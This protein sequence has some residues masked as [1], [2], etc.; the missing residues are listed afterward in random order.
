MSILE[1]TRPTRY[2]I[3]EWAHYT[4]V[5]NSYIR[6]ESHY[7]PSVG[8]PVTD[9]SL[10]DGGWIGIYEKRCVS[11]TF[12]YALLVVCAPDSRTFDA[13][14][15]TCRKDHHDLSSVHDTFE[16]VIRPYKDLAI[17]TRIA[18]TTRVAE[19]LGF[20]TGAPSASPSMV[21]WF[22][23]VP[24][25][26]VGAYLPRRRPKGCPEL[27]DPFPNAPLA[28]MRRD[29]QIVDYLLDDFRVYDESTY[30]RYSMC[31]SIRNGRHVTVRGPFD[32]VHIQHCTDEVPLDQVAVLFGAP[33]QYLPLATLATSTNPN[34]NTI[35]VTWE[36][37]AILTNRLTCEQYSQDSFPPSG[38]WSKLTYL[39]L[40]IRVSCR[41]MNGLSK[42]VD[43]QRRMSGFLAELRE[44][45]SL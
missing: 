17:A 7:P 36:D 2:T 18:L 40:F 24:N 23:P 10:G 19:L 25:P 30:A 11:D 12:V 27:P 41:D 37:E 22:P 13:L 21:D 20:L 44:F 43:D 4:R 14:Y 33:A 35:H 28:E 26:P 29:D 38:T 32:P 1:Y 39:P 31:Q 45:E 5:L 34:A 3:D 15:E 6:D 42:K 8:S 16:Q 9:V